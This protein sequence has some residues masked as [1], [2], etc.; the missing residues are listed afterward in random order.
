[1]SWTL[2]SIGEKGNSYCLLF[3]ILQN[4]SWDFFFHEFW[5]PLLC[6]H[7]GIAYKLL[8]LTGVTKVVPSP[9]TYLM[10]WFFT[11]MTQTREFPAMFKIMSKDC[12]VVVAIRAD[13]DMASGVWSISSLPVFCY[14]VIKFS[15]PVV[16]V[17]NLL[18]AATFFV[19]KRNLV[20]CNL[21]AVK[22][23]NT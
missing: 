10:S 8:L 12:T 15:K 5:F 23:N 11:M 20:I 3:C 21:L 13:S 17:N 1:M 7:S 2:S 4:E 16:I 14:L 19:V 6:Y 18:T 9:P 22:R